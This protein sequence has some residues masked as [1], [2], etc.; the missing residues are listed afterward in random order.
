MKTPLAIPPSK[1]L[2]ITGGNGFIGTRLQQRARE[3]GK[4]VTIFSR[5][6]EDKKETRFFSTITVPDL[7]S[8]QC[9]IHLAGEPILGIWTR[10]KRRRILES[11]REGTRRIVEAIA[12]SSNPPSVLISG[13]AIGF[14]GDRGHEALDESSPPGNGFLSEVTQVWEEEAMKASRYGVRVVL[15]RTGLVLGRKGGFLRLISPLFRYG[16]GSTLGS[17]TQEM[18][19]IHLDDLV[20][21]ILYCCADPLIAGPINAVMPSPLTNREFTEA[22]A[23]TLRRPYFLKLPAFLL[24]MTLGDLS[25][26]LLDSQHVEPKKALA[27]HFEFRYPTVSQAL[28]EIFYEPPC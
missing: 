20:A 13:S 7:T 17:G 1:R 25:H 8:I 19:C 18:S 15:L 12:Q 2:G 27:N 16:L 28:K 6:L 9:L 11:R 21:L 24:R 10:E 23:T 14:Y 3:C 22:L 5:H 26:L 4:E